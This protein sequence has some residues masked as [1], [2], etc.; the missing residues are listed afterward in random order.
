MAFTVILRA[1]V[2]DFGKQ[3][4]MFDGLEQQR[5]QIG[6]NLKAY[7]NEQSPNYS[8]VMVTAP[9]RGHTNRCLFTYYMVHAGIGIAYIRV[10]TDAYYRK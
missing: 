10:G 6:I 9:S 7:K 4:A 8:Y 1:E 3:K 2:K 5:Q